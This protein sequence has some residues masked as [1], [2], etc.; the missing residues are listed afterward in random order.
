MAEV[1]WHVV[2]N[3]LDFL[4]SAVHLLGSGESRK[5]QYAALPLS[6]SIETLLKV[7]LSR[8][9]WTLVVS[10]PGHARRKD[11]ET[12]DFKSVT[13]DQAVERLVEIAGVAIS[14]EDRK[15]IKNLNRTRNQIAHFALIESNP[16]APLLVFLMTSMC[17]RRTGKQ[18]RHP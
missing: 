1:N 18:A 15:W 16:L 10:E 2:N 14:D 5:V 8:E 3:G 6:A 13:I 12:G 4:A 17:C 9:H 11:Y 7:R